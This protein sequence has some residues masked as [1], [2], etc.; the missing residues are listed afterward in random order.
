LPLVVLVASVVL[1]LPLAPRYVATMAEARL[2]EA[3]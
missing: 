1:L 3:A 2:A